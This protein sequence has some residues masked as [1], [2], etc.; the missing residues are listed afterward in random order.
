MYVTIGA[1]IVERENKDNELDRDSIPN[2]SGLAP[3][4]ARFPDKQKKLRNSCRSDYLACVLTQKELRRGGFL[5]T[6]AR[7]S[8]HC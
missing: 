3:L 6:I 5:S 4:R 8:L 2:R 7:L 1:G